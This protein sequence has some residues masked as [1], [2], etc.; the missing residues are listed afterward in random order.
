MPKLAGINHLKAIHALE[1]A[2]FRVARQGKH[3]SMTR[4]P[5][6]IVVPRQN[7]IDPFTMGGIIRAAGLTIP[8][9]KALL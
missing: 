2:G 3:V 1:K 8:E 7:P 6:L 4:G 5:Q 9:F